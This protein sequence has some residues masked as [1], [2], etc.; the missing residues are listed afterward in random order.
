MF[1]PKVG[2]I[3]FGPA[4]SHPSLKPSKPVRRQPEASPSEQVAMFAALEPGAQ[5]IPCAPLDDVV[6][7]SIAISLKRIA[8][9]LERPKVETFHPLAQFDPCDDVLRKAAGL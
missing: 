3:V 4:S 9:A 1:D 5:L 2:S 7:A 8:D 6:Q